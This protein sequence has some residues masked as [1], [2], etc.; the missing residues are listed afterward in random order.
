[1]ATAVSLDWTS[2]ACTVIRHQ[3]QLT[4]WALP[5]MQALSLTGSY[6]GT[7]LTRLQARQWRIRTKSNCSLNHWRRSPPGANGG[8]CPQT[9]PKPSPEIIV[10]PLRKFS[11]RRR[12]GECRY[13]VT[14]RFRCRLKVVC[15]VC[16]ST[17]NIKEKGK[18]WNSIG[19]LTAKMLSAYFAPWPG[20]LSLDSAGSTSPDPRYKFA[21]QWRHVYVMNKIS[22]QLIY[23]EH[24]FLFLDM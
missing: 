10:N 14:R 20:A 1:M 8:N 4:T 21:W 17:G 6:P 3:S 19:R 15:A 2:L 7:C 24:L 5:R 9:V 13:N 22:K 23:R 12:V 11:W 18:V 16:A